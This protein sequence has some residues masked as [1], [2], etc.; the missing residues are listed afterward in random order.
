MGCMIGSSEPVI[1]SLWEAIFCQWQ[2][3]T[4]SSHQNCSLTVSHKPIAIGPSD[5]Q[6][7]LK[8]WP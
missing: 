4:V 2:R 3:P 5:K 8:P 1:D 6:N 7:E